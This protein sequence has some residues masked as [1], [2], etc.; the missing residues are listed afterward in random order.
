M[1]AQEATTRPTFLSAGPDGDPGVIGAQRHRGH[2]ERTLASRSR[3]LVAEDY[4]TAGDGYFAD[5][6]EAAQLGAERV[7]DTFLRRAR[8]CW[9]VAQALRASRPGQPERTP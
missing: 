9:H 3:P 8:A 6:T 2:G 5:A 1:S 4:D 7:A